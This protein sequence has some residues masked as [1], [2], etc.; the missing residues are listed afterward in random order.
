M[1]AAPRAKRSSVNSRDLYFLARQGLRSPVGL[2]IGFL[3]AASASAVQ[4]GAVYY[5]QV[6]INALAQR[7][8]ASVIPAVE[9][10]GL[11]VIVFETLEF[12]AGF[13]FYGRTGPRVTWLLRRDQVHSMLGAECEG[14]KEYSVGELVRRVQDDAGASAPYLTRGVF[15]LGRVVCSAI[16][17]FAYIWWQSRS[18]ALL[19]L[20]GAP[21]P[22]VVVLAFARWLVASQHRIQQVRDVEANAVVDW[23][24]G[25]EEYKA[26]RLEPRISSR[27]DSILDRHHAAARAAGLAEIVSNRIDA[28]ARQLTTIGLFLLAGLEAAHGEVSLGFLIAYLQLVGQLQMPF[29]TL[30]S[31]LRGG[32]AAAVSASRAAELVDLPG[33]SGSQHRP[34]G[35]WHALETHGVRVQTGGAT[36]AVP[37]LSLRPG[38][39]IGLSGANGV[40]KSTTL[41]VLLRL[42]TPSVGEVLLDGAPI[43][44]LDVHEYRALFAVASQRPYFF[45]GSVRDNLDPLANF[46]DDEL[47]A[48]LE[49]TGLSQEWQ[50]HGGL[51]KQ[52]KN[53]GAN[54]S[55]GE[56]AKLALA[57]V[58]LRQDA[59]IVILDEPFAAV[60]S[61]SRRLMAPVIEQ[62]LRPRAALI[63]AHEWDGLFSCDAYIRVGA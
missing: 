22:F 15:L 35:L 4:L 43:R 63:V 62:Y 13:V 38:L 44:D 6:L 48:A 49:A 12:L 16:F 17:A 32:A 47:V 9:G 54:I 26:L 56:R 41:R 19:A 39:H 11:A 27:L 18:L 28:L 3:A 7:T 20:A 24:D 46:N 42:V 52:L 14:V 2:G 31:Y 21:I 1:L 61:A 50:S 23:C 30:A 37:D 33:E 8:A 25:L 59:Q 10:V 55:P 57:R 45:A 51:G 5:M 40:G 29:S 53:G 60:D 36:I 58:L 34:L